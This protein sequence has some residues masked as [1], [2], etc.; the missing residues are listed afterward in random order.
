[1]ENSI[2]KQKLSYITAKAED[3]LEYLNMVKKTENQIKKIIGYKD[4]ESKDT[5]V[6]GP[7]ISEVHNFKKMLDKKAAEINMSIISKAYDE[8]KEESQNR[9]SNY[10]QITWYIANKYNLSKSIPK[11]WPVLGNIT[12]PFGYRIHPLSLSYE[13]HSGVDISQEPGTP[14]KST[15]DGVVRYAGWQAGYGMAVLI[16]HGGGY[17]TLYGHMSEILVKEGEKINREQIIGRVGSTGTSTG[18]HLHYE[19]WEFGKAVNPTKYIEHYKSKEITNVLAF[20]NIF[21]R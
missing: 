4:T 9:L 16:D 15:A 2:M 7:S 18:P 14:I 17:S 5:N 8:I 20:E 11:G 19:V 21:G 12:S 13:F 6:G 10:S 3:S 1:M